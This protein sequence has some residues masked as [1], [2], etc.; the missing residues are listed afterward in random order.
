MIW[1]LCPCCPCLFQTVDT[2]AN[3][4]KDP[5]AGRWH[6]LRTAHTTK[7][8]Q[9]CWWVDFFSFIM[10]DVSYGSSLTPT[11]LDKSPANSSKHYMSSWN[12]SDIHAYA[13][14]Q[15]LRVPAATEAYRS[16][17]RMP[18]II[19]ILLTYPLSGRNC[20][21]PLR[22][23]AIGTSWVRLPVIT[24]WFI[25]RWAVKQLSP[26][27]AQSMVWKWPRLASRDSGKP[28]ASQSASLDWKSSRC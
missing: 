5:Y 21:H 25:G 14:D 4:R 11:S 2:Q 1:Q 10:T 20:Q 7:R 24:C 9:N 28:R 15:Q 8:R 19:F 26:C 17:D 16:P 27:S 23:L 13:Q 12:M 3:Y 6:F 22:R 18:Y